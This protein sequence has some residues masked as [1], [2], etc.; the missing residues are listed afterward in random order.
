MP[1]GRC[2]N[3]HSDLQ[4]QSQN[5]KASSRVTIASQR[6]QDCSHISTC[7]P[8]S[9]LCILSNENLLLSQATSWTN[10]ERLDNISLVV[11]ELWRRLR[12][13]SLWNEFFRPREVSLVAVCGMVT[14]RDVRLAGK[15][16]NRQNKQA[17][18]DSRFQV[19]S[20]Q[21][22][23]ALLLPRRVEQ[24]ESRLAGR[25]AWSLKGLQ[26]CTAAR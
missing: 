6:T 14:Y 2:T 5:A 9:E 12:E 26:S 15:S 22:Y 24:L 21:Q 19:R 17:S 3:H 16:G 8:N 18:T 1:S 13:P 23:V 7:T 4:A 25:H 20:N 10:H 11:L